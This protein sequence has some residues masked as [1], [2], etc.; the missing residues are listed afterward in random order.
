MYQYKC[1]VVA[2]DSLRLLRD[3]PIQDHLGTQIDLIKAGSMWKV[4]P[5]V[6]SDP[7]VVWLR[8]PRGDRQTWDSDESLF[9]EFEVVDNEAG[10]NHEGE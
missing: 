1:G 7:S 8:D 3:L 10:E 9:S 2:G 5:G 6:K 4:L